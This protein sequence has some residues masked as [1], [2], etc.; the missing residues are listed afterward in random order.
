MVVGCGGC[1]TMFRMFVVVVC[2]CGLLRYGSLLRRVIA[3]EGF[4]DGAV[5]CIDC[6]IR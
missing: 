1:L 2:C 3:V 4:C 6:A 5:R